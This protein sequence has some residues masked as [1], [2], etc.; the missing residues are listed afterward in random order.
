MIENNSLLSAILNEII[1]FFFGHNGKQN[2]IYLK[3]QII[4]EKGIS[5]PQTRTEVLLSIG[6]SSEAAVRLCAQHSINHLIRFTAEKIF[7]YKKERVK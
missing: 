3:N 5:R 6:Q 1:G 4:R 7:G 2:E